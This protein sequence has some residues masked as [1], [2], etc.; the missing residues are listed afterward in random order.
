MAGKNITGNK[1]GKLTAIRSTG[2]KS[3]NGDFIWD[4]TCDCGNTCQTTIGR[5]NFGQ[6]RSCGCLLSE[7]C[8]SRTHGKSKG[9]KVYTSWRKIKERCFNTNCLDYQTHGARGITMCEQFKKDFMAFYNEVGEPPENTREWSIDRIDNTKG[10]ETGNLR[11]ARSEQQARNKGKMK[12]NVSG[13]TGVCWEDKLHPDGI[14]ST[15]YA[16]AQWHEYENKVKIDCKKS[17]SV[18][19]YG[20]LPAFAMACKH[21]ESKIKELND[22]GCGYSASHGK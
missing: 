19:K 5:L 3:K 8:A 13:V 16:V 14:K 7:N 18:K 21:R 1:Y 17:F 22:Q 15:T 6:K 12:N 2:I 9:C 4:C 20:L 11:W 10:Y